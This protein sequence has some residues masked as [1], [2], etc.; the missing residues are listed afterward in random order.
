MIVVVVG[1]HCDVIICELVVGVVRH[2]AA[3]TAAAKSIA[4]GRGN[5]VGL[6]S[7]LDQRQFFYCFEP[8]LASLIQ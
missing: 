6:T 5:A 1:F 2:G 8:L 7:I 4:R 3:E